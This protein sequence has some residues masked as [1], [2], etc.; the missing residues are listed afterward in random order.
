MIMPQVAGNPPLRPNSAV[1]TYT[2][3]NPTWA[4][5]GVGSTVDYSDAAT[6]TSTAATNV[7]TFSF[8]A[9]TGNGSLRIGLY[10]ITTHDVLS[11]DDTNEAISSVTI[12]VSTDGS[13]YAQIFN[14]T[15]GANDQV[16]GLVTYRIPTNQDMSLFKVE[17]TVVG[18]HLGSGVSLAIASAECDISDIVVF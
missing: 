15:G 1:Y 12:S 10:N 16:S 17:I 9:G 8:A 2:P 18:V 7:M 3:T 13:T 5:N 4:Y 11:S 14:D 6:Y